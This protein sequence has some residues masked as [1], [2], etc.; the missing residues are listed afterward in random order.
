MELAAC[1]KLEDMVGNAEIRVRMGER[2]KGGRVGM[3]EG[4]EVWRRDL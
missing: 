3:A 1:R 4:R 2:Y